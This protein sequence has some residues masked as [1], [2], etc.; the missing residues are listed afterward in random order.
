[1]T[2]PAT[3]LCGGGT[4]ASSGGTAVWSTRTASADHD[5]VCDALLGRV[6]GRIE[7]DVALLALAVGR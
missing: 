1:M 3:G 7:D 5:P 4:S 2:A 6:S